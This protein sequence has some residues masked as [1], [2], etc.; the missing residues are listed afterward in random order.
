ML[1]E[2]NILQGYEAARQMYAQ[3]GVDTE[4]AMK[5]CGRVPISVHCWQL[6]DCTGLEARSG[7]LT[8]GIQTTGNYPGKARNFDEIK[9]DY[10]KALSYIPGSKKLSIHAMYLDNHGKPVD[11]DQIEPEHFDGWIDFANELDVGLDFNPT[12]FSH[13]KSS[14]GYTLSSSDE[15]IRSFWVEH[16]KRCRKVAGY[17]AKRTGKPVMNNIWI[18][19]GE[20]EFPID[21][22]SPRERLRESLDE[23]LQEK[24]PGLTDS[25]E[26]KLFGIGSECYVTGSHEFYMGYTVS[27]GNVYLTLD[28][29][30]F[31]PTETVSGKLSA[32]LPFVPGVLLHV[33]RP[34]RWDSDHVV[35]YNDELRRAALELVRFNR[36]DKIQVALDYFDASVNRV[37]ALAV[38]ARNM[39]KALL[40]AFLTPNATLRKMEEKGDT[41]ARLAVQ[42]E[43]KVM[44]LG[45][46]WNYYCLKNGVAPDMDWITDAQKYE[47]KVLASR[48]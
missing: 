27:H 9:A 42:E 8:G 39:R 41:S 19:D 21:T 11:R 40:E 34:E 18:P 13:E 12:F 37:I 46:V 22:L 24:Y 32:I 35:A 17:I 28:T 38:G 43:C 29:G 33:S 45:L 10:E 47:R 26:S 20:K 44:P 31:H 36:F 3:M 15:A 16:G 14:S 30:H 23:I 48:V 4:K 25:L 1:T 5:A 2:A 6:D 7:A